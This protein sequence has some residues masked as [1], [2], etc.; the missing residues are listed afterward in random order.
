MGAGEP[1][2]TVTLTGEVP[3]DGAHCEAAL[4]VFVCGTTTTTAPSTTTTAPSTTTTASTTTTQTDPRDLTIPPTQ[5]YPA[6]GTA[7][8]EAGG[9]Y[10]II[11]SNAETGTVWWTAPYWCSNGLDMYPG[12]GCWVSGDREGYRC[13]YGFVKDAAGEI[14]GRFAF[15][16]PEGQTYTKINDKYMEEA[17]RYLDGSPTPYFGTNAK[18]IPEEDCLDVRSDIDYSGACRP[19]DE[20]PRVGFFDGEGDVLDIRDYS[21]TD[22]TNVIFNLFDFVGTRATVIAC[23][24]GLVATIVYYDA[25]GPGQL[26]VD[27]NGTGPHADN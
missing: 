14:T 19:V 17:E 2:Q 22:A 5:P 8:Y 21:N 24:D 26:A 6:R 18:E 13:A 25:L 7:P 20:R 3:P 15:V 10:D 9:G 23:E 4:E 12:Q 16:R 27:F 1:E 11:A